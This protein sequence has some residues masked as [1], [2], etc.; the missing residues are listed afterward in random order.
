M[1]EYAENSD[2][3]ELGSSPLPSLPFSLYLSHTHEATL[4]FVNQ[5]QE[6]R[7]YQNSLIL[8]YK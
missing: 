2:Y 1:L 5:R 6:M 7:V 3:Y 8:F 4:T